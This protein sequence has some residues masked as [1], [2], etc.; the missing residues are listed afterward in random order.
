VNFEQLIRMM[1][2]ADVARH[3]GTSRVPKTRSAG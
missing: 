2:D 3:Q 1:V